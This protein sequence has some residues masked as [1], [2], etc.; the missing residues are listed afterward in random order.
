M[1]RWRRMHEVW[2]L[3]PCRQWRSVWGGTYPECTLKERKR[4]TEKAQHHP[5]SLVNRECGEDLFLEITF[6]EQKSTFLGAKT[7]LLEIIF[8]CDQ[9]APFWRR[10][11]SKLYL[12]RPFKIAK[13]FQRPG[14]APYPHYATASA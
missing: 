9:K 1:T 3:I 14:G 12:V 7:F 8:F 10:R 5:G 11:S 4:L 2:G 6:S 13:V